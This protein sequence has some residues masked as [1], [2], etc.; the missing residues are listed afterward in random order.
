[1]ATSVLVGLPV[2]SH[3]NSALCTATFTNVT[4]SGGTARSASLAETET[5]DDE[6]SR[7]IR[8]FPNPLEGNTLNIE[9]TIPSTSTVR[10]QI[11]NLL[12]QVVMEKDLGRQEAGTIRYDVDLSAFPKGTFIVRVF[13]VRSNQS[14]I[15][16]RQ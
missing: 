12:G 9:S 15:F 11:A 3:N 7:S 4:V 8:V 5:F 16:V 6:S 1:M 2:T 14:A 10:I 13:S